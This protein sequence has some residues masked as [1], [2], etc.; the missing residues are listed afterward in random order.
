MSHQCKLVALKNL[1]I[2]IEEL[3]INVEEKKK[4]LDLIKRATEQVIKGG[5]ID[6]FWTKIDFLKTLFQR[7]TK[8]N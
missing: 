3:R 8:V 5:I 4:F 2:E 6:N 7:I 1:K